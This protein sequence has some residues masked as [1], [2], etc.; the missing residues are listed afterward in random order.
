MQWIR[1]TESMLVASFSI[2]GSLQQADQLKKEHEQ[3]QVAIEVRDF[4]N[5]IIYIYNILYIKIG[6]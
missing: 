2:P 5:N 6:K 1:N 4:L 3:F